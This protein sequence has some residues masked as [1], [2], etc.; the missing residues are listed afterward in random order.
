MFFHSSGTSDEF[1][2]AKQAAY[3]AKYTAWNATAL[4]KIELFTLE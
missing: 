1:L 4:V 3:E 2:P